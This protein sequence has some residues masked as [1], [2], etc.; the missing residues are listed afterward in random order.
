MCTLNDWFFKSVRGCSINQAHC[1]FKQVIINRTKE[2]VITEDIFLNENIIVETSTI[3]ESEDI[4][5]EIEVELKPILPPY[6]NPSRD[7]KSTTNSL[8]G[9]EFVAIIHRVYDEIVQW[10]K[11]FFKVPS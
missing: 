8:N 10:R 6:T 1:K 2:D 5:I 7:V 4:D 11:N 3:V 9:H